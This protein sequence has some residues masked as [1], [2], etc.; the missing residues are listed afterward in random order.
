MPFSLTKETD[1]AKDAYI[2]FVH[3]AAIGAAVITKLRKDFEAKF[4]HVT[5]EDVE[6]WTEH[7]FQA[8][9]E[10]REELEEAAEKVLSGKG[11][12]RSRTG[13][14]VP[15]TAKI[16]EAL[17][18]LISH[19]NGALGTKYEG[20]LVGADVKKETEARLQKNY[21]GAKLQSNYNQVPIALTDKDKKAGRKTSALKWICLGDA[22]KNP[23]GKLGVDKEV[24]IKAT[25]EG[26]TAVIAEQSDDI[27]AEFNKTG[28]KLH[29]QLSKLLDK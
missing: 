22:V 23:S 26:I 3:R 19:V 27:Q 24:D 25:L 29:E 18:V 7:C 11:L 21:P 12:T 4:P 13:P 2:E 28:K 20:K 9:K 6:N 10:R 15:L 14:S 8:F 17:G 16:E 5:S 1:E